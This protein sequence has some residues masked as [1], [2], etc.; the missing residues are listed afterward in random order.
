MKVVM[1]TYLEE[2][3][4]T[5]LSLYYVIQH[6]C[7]KGSASHFAEHFTAEKSGCGVLHTI[8]QKELDARCALREHRP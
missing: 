1:E 7:T 8:R 3:I 2:N 6:T 5:V 4:Q